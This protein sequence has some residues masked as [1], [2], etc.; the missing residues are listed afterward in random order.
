LPNRS[1]KQWGGI[2]AWWKN[3]NKNPKEK[4]V[5]EWGG[6]FIILS[7]RIDTNVF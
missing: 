3:N 6:W 2:H 4:K 7:A 5:M 1:F